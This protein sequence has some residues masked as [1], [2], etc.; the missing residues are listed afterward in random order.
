MG[1]EGIWKK[2]SGGG[3]GFRGDGDEMTKEQKKRMHICNRW[4]LFPWI[5]RDVCLGYVIKT[6]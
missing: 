5:T 1:S 4:F 2:I 3:Y 6:H